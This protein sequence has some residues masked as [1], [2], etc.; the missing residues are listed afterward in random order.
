MTQGP[1]G[2]VEMGILDHIRE[3]RKRLVISV[4]AIVILSIV[5]YSFSEIIFGWLCSPFFTAF[6]GDMLIGTGPAEAFVLKVKVACFGG[7]VL[8]CPV[9]FHQL[10]LF[11]AP[12]LYENERRMVMPFVVSASA[13]LLLGVIFCYYLVLPFA[14]DFFRAQY[15]S[16]GLTPAIRLSEHL[17]TTIWSLLAFGLVFEMPMVAFFLGRAGIID[18]TTLL[19]GG[20][21]AIVTIFIVAAVFTPPDVL[22]Q[23][24]MAGPLLLLYAISIAVV[25]YTARRPKSAASQSEVKAP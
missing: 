21:Y 16:I 18:H 12:G 1:S 7:L 17:A 10:W 13:L 6:P 22:S 24:L 15:Q 14:F 20:R 2:V 11:V 5:A 4:I 3:L 19:R 23:F 9:I 25:R 8:A